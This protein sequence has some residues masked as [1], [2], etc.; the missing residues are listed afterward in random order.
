MKKAKAKLPGEKK[1]LKS[2]KF[3]KLKKPDAPKVI[4]KIKRRGRPPG[5]TNKK[6]IKKPVVEPEEITWKTFKLLG[7]CPRNACGL[8]IHSSDLVSKQV[9]LCP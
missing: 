4:S 2:P 5:S 3:P 6:G 1:S 9:F 8:M 7:F